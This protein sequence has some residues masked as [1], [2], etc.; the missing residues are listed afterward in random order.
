MEQDL[1]DSHNVY[2]REWEEFYKPRDG[3]E[4]FGFSRLESR[5]PRLFMGLYTAS[6]LGLVV[7]TALGWV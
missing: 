7:A 1:A 4:R 5:L 3:K 2:S 6:L